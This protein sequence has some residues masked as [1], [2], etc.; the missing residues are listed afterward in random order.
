[1]SED[2]GTD[3]PAILYVDQTDEIMALLDA[4]AITRGTPVIVLV[5]GA[6]GMDDDAV[7]GLEEVLRGT[8]IPAVARCAGTIVDGGTDSGIMRAIG[9]A[10][11]DSDGTFPLIG[12]AARGT[13]ALSTTSPV[14]GSA[15]VDRHHTHLVVVPGTEWG[16]EGE[17]L[18]LVADVIAGGRRS[19]TVLANGGEIAYDDV[20]RSLDRGRPVI[21]LAGTGRTADAIAD[22]AAGRA[23]EPRAQLIARSGLTRVVN[24]DDL[25]ALQTAILEELGV[26]EGSMTTERPGRGAEGG[27]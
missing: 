21:V 15:P 14:T 25:D 1:M 16:D 12:V 20:G 5:G 4:A 18:A 6:G 22:V 17:W 19:V 23:E 13:V 2:T 7:A 24:T 11:A 27:T 10:R 26:T 9:R 8:V 3:G